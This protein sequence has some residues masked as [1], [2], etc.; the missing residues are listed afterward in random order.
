MPT[1]KQWYLIIS[2][3]ISGLITGAALFTTLFGQDTTIKIVACLGIANIVLTAVGTAF[4]TQT[5]QVK[6]VLAMPGVEK[7]DVN[8]QAS[9]A[10]AVLAVD[11]ATNK[12]AP[13]PA[14]QVA[15]AQKASS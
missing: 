13:T 15:V 12:I 4:S 3:T 2:S 9:K 6:D 10:L 11:P 7:I 1:N 8:E 5:E 14:A